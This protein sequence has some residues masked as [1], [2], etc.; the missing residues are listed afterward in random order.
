[1]LVCVALYCAVPSCNGIV[2]IDQVHHPFTKPV[3]TTTPVEVYII[4]REPISPV[5]VK[6]GMAVLVFV[7]LAGV[8]ITGAGITKQEIFTIPVA[9]LLTAPLRS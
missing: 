6:V 4:I 1:M 8:R 9:R 7:P 2:I 5:P 3:P